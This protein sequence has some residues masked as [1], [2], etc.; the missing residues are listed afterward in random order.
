MGEMRERAVE[1]QDVGD[2]KLLGPRGK[3]WIGVKVWFG[4]VMRLVRK[5]TDHEGGIEPPR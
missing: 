1:E 4:C 2:G 5:D 3:K